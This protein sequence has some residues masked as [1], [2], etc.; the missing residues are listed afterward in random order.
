MDSCSDYFGMTIDSDG[1]QSPSFYWFR[2]D[3]EPT[4]S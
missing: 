2:W 3:P 1:I 4:I